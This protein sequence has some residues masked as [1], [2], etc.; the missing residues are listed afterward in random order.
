MREG[1]RLQRKCAR[2]GALLAACSVAGLALSQT[3]GSTP[4][5]QTQENLRR[6]EELARQRQPRQVG[7]DQLAAPTR[8]VVAPIPDETPCFVISQVRLLGDPDQQFG[9]LGSHYARF[10]GSCLGVKGLGLLARALDDAL[11]RRGF[12]TTRVSFPAQNLETGTVTLQLHIGRVSSVQWVTARPDASASSEPDRRWGTWRNAMPLRPGDILNIR[13]LEQGVEQM[14][15]LP[16]QDVRTKLLPGEQA[17]TSIVLIERAAAAWHERVRGGITLDNTG[18]RALGRAQAS[19]NLALDNPAGLNDL[20]S[21]SFG[22]NVERVGRNHRSQ[23]LGVNYSIPWGY[24]TFSLSAS[25]SEFAQYV[26][27]TT[28]QFLSSGESQSIEARWQRVVWRGSSAKLGVQ[29]AAGTRRARSYLDD[30]ELLVQR[31]RTAQAELGVNFKQL[32]E[33]ATLEVDIGVRQGT[34]WWNAQPDLEGSDAEGATLRPRIWTLGA[35]LYAALP[36]GWQY[37]LAL[38]GQH[39]RERTLSV[40]QFAIGGRS[41]VRGF[42]GDAVL[43]A[44]RGVVVRNELTAQL[45]RWLQIDS[46]AVLAL[47]WGWVGGPSASQLAGHHLAGLAVGLRG[48]SHGFVFDLAAGAPLYKPRGFETRRISIYASLTRVF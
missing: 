34:G 37:S 2:M 30:V 23:S 7:P 35:Q 38:R 42:D 31:R 14:K 3:P 28:V 6:Q 22:S 48:Q 20:L 46:Q 41:T 45:P 15:R 1:S 40:D 4:E 11:V 18:G 16:S 26:Q 5:A 27:G 10:L 9:W 43:L 47:D 29:V 36:R 17:D 13:D 39:A 25:Q 8:E 33:A 12:A 44:E 19:A 21:A 32:W 24:N